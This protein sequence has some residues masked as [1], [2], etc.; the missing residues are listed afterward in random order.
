MQFQKRFYNKLFRSCHLQKTSN[1]LFR[2]LIKNK[3]DQL[4]L[5]SLKVDSINLH[6]VDRQLQL[7]MDQKNSNQK[8]KLQ[9]INPEEMT[10]LNHLRQ[11]Q[12][13]RIELHKEKIFQRSEMKQQIMK[14]YLKQMF[15]IQLMLSINQSKMKNRMRI[16]KL[17]LLNK[18][19]HPNI[20]MRKKKKKK[21]KHKTLIITQA[22]II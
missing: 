22:L 6:L 1:H 10:H 14:F 12:T 4:W 20:H 17:N 9:M 2:Y 15:T 19:P 8:A 21:L 3:R 18:D 11:N 7:Q 13:L 16:Q 5:C